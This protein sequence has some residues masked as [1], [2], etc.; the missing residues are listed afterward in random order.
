MG[1]VDWQEPETQL[2]A[3]NWRRRAKHFDLAPLAGDRRALDVDAMPFASPDVLVAEEEP[4]AAEIQAVDADEVVEE[5]GESA[6]EPEESPAAAD[7]DP[8]RVYLRH[9]GRTRL[10]T[11]ADEVQIGEQI[12]RARHELLASLAAVPDAVDCLA[13]LADMVAEGKT[14]AAELILL[15]DGGELKPE[16]IQPVL[17]TFA[18]IKRENRWNDRRRRERAI[19]KR[20]CELPI[21]PSVVDEIVAKVDDARV[22]DADARLTEAK[23]RLIEA[24]LRLVVSIAKRYIGRGL[25]LLDLIQEG[26]IGLMK[27]VD[28]FQFRRGFRFS[29][30]ATWWIRQ[31]VARGVADY[32]RT[33]RLPVHVVES[34]AKLEKARRELT[35]RT[36]REP[37]E[38]ELARAAKMDDEKVRL[39]QMAAKLPMSLDA[40]VKA[41][42]ETAFG[43]L[44]ADQAAESPE[45]E[46]VRRNLAEHLERALAPLDSR[47]KEVLRL[48]FGLTN[49]QEHTLAE[50]ARRLGL[51]RERVRQIEQRAMLKLRKA[52]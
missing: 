44:M 12:E 30:Y 25:S 31:A 19:A 4:E 11:A 39:L 33:V 6:E 16:R 41:E 49:S 8:V 15:P 46:L 5:P 7:A 9:I 37:S 43:E 42:E 10:L 40:P 1:V 52:S 27:A 18:K 36:G 23:R 2:D 24:N 14:P 17:D 22:K 38:H 45:D 51:S 26:N 50:I 32:G 29:T 13:S 35:E 48:R 20:L 34:L 3:L 28:R 21:R 47:E